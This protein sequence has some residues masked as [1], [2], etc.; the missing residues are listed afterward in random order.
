M[1][2]HPRTALVL[3]SLLLAAVLP[4][5]CGI[6][7]DRSVCPCYVSLKDTSA[8]EVKDGSS[9][10][11]WFLAG[12]STLD[13]Y[14]NLESGD[15][16]GLREIPVGRKTDRVHVWKGISHKSVIDIGSMSILF[17]STDT[18]PLFWASAELDCNAEEAYAEFGMKR[19]YARL[20]I[21]V[22]P[23]GFGSRPESIRITGSTGGYYADKSLA[24]VPLRIE[25]SAA[26]TKASGGTADMV[27]FEANI[28]QQKN[29]DKLELTV[30]GEDHSFS[31]YNLGMLIR[32]AG[33]KSEDD[34]A[35]FSDIHIT[36]DNIQKTLSVTI[37]QWDIHNYSITI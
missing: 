1:T 15:T 4:A 12:Q 13:S 20:I 31:G 23:S 37:E 30:I 11:V 19:M 29:L 7:E 22:I 8:I 6:K 25:K 18:D 32:S 21:D 16:A 26:R 5:A 36:I 28:G 24:A 17:N 10:L 9:T 33:I 3:T 27:T 35:F 34:P 14:F 2:S